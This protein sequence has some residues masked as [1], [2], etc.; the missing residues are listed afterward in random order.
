MEPLRGRIN[1]AD[2]R[3]DVG[4][5]FARSGVRADVRRAIVTY[6]SKDPTIESRHTDD[7]LV[8]GR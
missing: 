3:A 1:A 5:D 7:S 4:G 2:I 8:P 6:H